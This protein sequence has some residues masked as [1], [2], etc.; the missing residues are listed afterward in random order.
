MHLSNLS[1]YAIN[2]NSPGFGEG[3][4]IRRVVVEA[5]VWIRRQPGR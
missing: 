3:A 2:N 5:P 4:D 1:Y